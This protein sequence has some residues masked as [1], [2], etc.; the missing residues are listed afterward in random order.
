MICTC[1]H[2]QNGA[3]SLSRSVNVRQTIREWYSTPRLRHPVQLGMAP[4]PSMT[5]MR[6][7]G[8]SH[9]SS[10]ESMANVSL[11]HLSQNR[12][13]EYENHAV[14]F[15]HRRKASREALFL[16]AISEL[17]SLS[18]TCIPHSALVYSFS[19]LSL[20]SPPTTVYLR[21]VACSSETWEGGA[22]LSVWHACLAS[23]IT[24][25][26][27]QPRGHDFACRHPWRQGFCLLGTFGSLVNAKT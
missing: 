9:T 18:T 11:H 25:I 6:L 17:C 3:K 13:Y 16:Q 5:Y 2:A 7:Q 27:Q 21:G 8:P 14:F 23:D 20:T 4:S 19:E 22:S 24:P 10:Q 15:M 1:R 12:L 26:N